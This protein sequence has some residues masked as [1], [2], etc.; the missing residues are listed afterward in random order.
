MSFLFF[1]FLRT[2]S[3]DSQLGLLLYNRQLMFIIL[4][5]LLCNPDLTCLWQEEIL[6]E[7]DEYVNIHN[8]LGYLATIG[9][10]LK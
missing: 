9:V 7:T 3:H 5:K 1:S 2:A 4:M 10:Q 8:R 6:D